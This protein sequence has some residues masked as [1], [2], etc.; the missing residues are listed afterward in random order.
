[1][2]SFSKLLHSHCLTHTCEMAHVQ[3]HICKGAHERT[4]NS[5]ILLAHAGRETYSHK[6]IMLCGERYLLL[7]ERTQDRAFGSSMRIRI[8]N[9]VGNLYYFSIFP[10]RPYTRRTHVFTKSI[11]ERIKLFRPLNQGSR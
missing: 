10:P 5:K 11:Y 3:G 8:S 2:K 9:K 1:M 4:Q 7:L 6:E